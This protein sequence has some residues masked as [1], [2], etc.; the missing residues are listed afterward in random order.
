[1]IRV[2]WDHPDAVRLREEMVAEVSGLYPADGGANHRDG[3]ARVDPADVVVTGLIYEDERAI[4]H[5]ALRRLGGDLEIKRMYIIPERRG[6]GLSRHLLD[7][8]EVAARTEGARR[9]ILHTGTHQHAAIELYTR[10]GYTAV[11]VFEPYIGLPDSLCFEKV[12][13]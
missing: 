6:L 11:P 4:A 3:S 7:E 2:A 8:M 13:G 10:Q 5:V 12:L 1:M 9:I